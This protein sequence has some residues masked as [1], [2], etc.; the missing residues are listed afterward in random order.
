MAKIKNVTYTVLVIFLA[1]VF[2]GCVSTKETKLEPKAEGKAL[3]DYITTGNSYKDWNKWPGK[4][5]LYPR[6]PGSPHG[7]FLTTYVSDNALSAIQDKKGILPDESI[8]VKENYDAN[9]K[10][11]ALTVMY[12]EEGYDPGH[13]DWFWAKYG[14]DGSVQAEGKVQACIDCHGTKKDNDFTFSSPLK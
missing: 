1:S 5:E 12:K 7:D 11:A 4:G 13:N 3:Y 8:I 10:L 9:K 14:I 6:S 2:L